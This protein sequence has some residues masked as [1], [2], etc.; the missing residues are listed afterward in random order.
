[1]KAA[2]PITIFI[3]LS[4]VGFPAQ[5]QERTEPE[6]DRPAV[7]P[8]R[9]LQLPEPKLTSDVSV[10]EALAA[11]RS[12]R[13]FTKKELNLEQVSQLAWA[14][15][16]ITKKDTGYR[17]APSAGAIYPIRL[18]F[19]IKGG[20]YVY[21]PGEHSLEKLINRDLR[22]AISQAALKQQ[23]L[24][25]AACDILITGSV[26]KVAAKYGP[27]ARQYM[28]LEAGHIAQNIHLQAVSLGLGSV[29]IG[30]FDGKKVERICRLPA[31]EEAIYLIAVGYPAGEAAI[32]GKTV[33]SQQAS[34]QLQE[35]EVKKAL[36]I[37]AEDKFVEKEFFDAQ[38]ILETAG[39]ETTVASWQLGILTGNNKGKT[40]AMVLLNDANVDDY[41]A[42]VILGAA[43]L[44]SHAEDQAVLNIARKA[45]EKGKVLAAIDEGPRFL[46]EA[47]VLRGI[48][49]T[50]ARKQKRRLLKGGA[51]YTGGDVERD[52]LIVTGGG[53]K[54]T[55]QFT[56]A[57]VEAV[58]GRETRQRDERDLGR[59]ISDKVQQRREK[60]QTQAP[61]AK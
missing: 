51:N 52:G 17:T 31:E 24:A 56:R 19:I 42:I 8:L 55:T 44:K 23:T 47:G 59:R 45:V 7:T 4:V 38:D 1:M 6:T 18:Y 25:K 20:I 13:Q 5:G 14:G 60:Y 61:E 40:E 35:P 43:E 36:L 39:I 28:L 3:L 10:E 15:Q 46:A 30:A 16:G 48:R 34:I 32:P 50:S 21:E 41:D 9:K 53:P 29:P 58:L 54:S 49:A 57:V 2:I 27:R 11:R 26:K 37:I 22:N 33:E 12:V